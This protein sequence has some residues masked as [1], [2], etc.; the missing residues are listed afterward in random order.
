MAKPLIMIVDDEVGVRELLT[1]ALR[2]AGLDTIEAKDGM[3]ALSMLRKNKPDLLIIDVN[4]PIMDGFDL[5]ERIRETKNNVPALMLTA[6]AERADVSRG[7]RLGADDYVTKPFGLEELLL[8]IRAILRRSKPAEESFS[9]LTCG[10]ISLNE[11]TY[12]VFL[13]EEQVDL[14]K[15]EFRLLQHLLQNKGRVLTK[16]SL[17]S[18]VWDIDFDSDTGVVDTYISYLRRKFHSEDFDG[19]KT[20]RGVGFQIVEPKAKK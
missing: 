14:S 9:I 20:V 17:L 3:S 10:P 8:R 1:D 2:I 18:E 7:L 6:R 4:M 19:I 12:E 15:T 13:G 5:L 11:E 16:S